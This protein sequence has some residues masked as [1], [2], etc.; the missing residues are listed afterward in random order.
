MTPAQQD[1]LAWAIETARMKATVA[2][3]ASFGS[4]SAYGKELNNRQFELF[5]ARANALQ[6]ML[7]AGAYA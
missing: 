5:T 7:E 2:Q 4:R 6:A 1:A 3:R